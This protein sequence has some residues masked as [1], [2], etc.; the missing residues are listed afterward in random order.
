MGGSGRTQ[1]TEP[2]FNAKYCGEDAE[3]LTC[4]TSS[5]ISASAGAEL[6]RRASALSALFGGWYRYP[7]KM[8]P[9]PPELIHV[10]GHVSVCT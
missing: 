8:G 10:F 4:A 7:P 6:L 1:S 3:M 5:T 2:V 9:I